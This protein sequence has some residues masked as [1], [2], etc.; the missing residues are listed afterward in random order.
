LSFICV[1]RILHKN[2]GMSE[3]W[4]KAHSV[5]HIVCST[6]CEKATMSRDTTSCSV[7]HGRFTQSDVAWHIVCFTRC[8]MPHHSARKNSHIV[9][10]GRVS[11]KNSS[12]PEAFTCDS[13]VRVC[14]SICLCV[15]VCVV[16]P[17]FGARGG[18]GLAHSCRAPTGSDHWPEVTQIG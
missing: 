5:K 12:C 17:S 11:R 10:I 4:G 16:L 15:S 1:F 6:L 7:R 9:W 3:W 8:A 13:C 18:G 2:V 14:L